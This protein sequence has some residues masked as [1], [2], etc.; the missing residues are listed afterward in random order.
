VTV[1]DKEGALSPLSTTVVAVASGPF[2]KALRLWQSNMLK[3]GHQVAAALAAAKDDPIADHFFGLTYYDAARVFYQIADFTGDSSWLATAD[4]AVQA[5]RDAYVIPNQGQVTGYWLFTR[6][7]TEDYLRTGDVASRDAVLMLAQK[8]AYAGDTVPASWTASW[9]R[10]REVAYNLLA[11]L[12]AESLG[13]AHRARTDLLAAQALGHLDQWTGAATAGYVRPFMVALSCEALIAYE[14]KTG[15]GRVLPAIRR[16]LDW[17]WEHC[18]DPKARA[19]GY[20]NIPAPDGSGGTGPAPDLNLLIA[21]AFGWV[22]HETGETVYRDRGDAIFAGG[23]D[24]AFLGNGKQ[25]NQNYRWSFDYV[26]WRNE[27]PLVG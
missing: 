7:L 14:A 24:Q 16:A 12:D 21:P 19:F 25:F 6:G 23:V 15:D 26:T 13:A 27:P 10:S 9:E 18:W 22:Y 17:I 5:Y 11:E 20:T 3:Y 1:A 2:D 8:A 4:L